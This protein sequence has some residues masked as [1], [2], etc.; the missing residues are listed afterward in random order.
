MNHISF[1]PTSQQQV[2]GQEGVMW[3]FS[4]ILCDGA[5]VRDCSLLPGGWQGMPERCH[6]AFTMLYPNDS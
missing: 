4:V 3:H 5:P 6:V 1:F 2:M